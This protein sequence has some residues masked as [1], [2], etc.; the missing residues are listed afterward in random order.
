MGKNNFHQERQKDGAV[1]GAVFG[2]PISANLRFNFN[3]GIFFFNSRF[4]RKHFLG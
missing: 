2:R 1:L 3:P 4:I